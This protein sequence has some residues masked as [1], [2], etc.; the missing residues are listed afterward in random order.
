MRLSHLA[1]MATLVALLGAMFVA[2]PSAGA[3]TADPPMCGTSK[4]L[5]LGNDANNDD[6]YEDAEDTAPQTCTVSKTSNAITAATN[7]RVTV[8]AGSGAVATFGAVDTSTTNTGEVTFTA[9][10]AGQ[11]TYRVSIVA[12][13]ALSEP[14][15]HKLTVVAFSEQQESTSSS[16]PNFKISFVDDA[17]D[18]VSPGSSVDV[19]VASSGGAML[20]Q[21]TVAGGLSFYE[22]TTVRTY[23]ADGD[24]PDDDLDVTVAATRTVVG[25]SLL[26]SNFKVEVATSDVD[27]VPGATVLGAPK[28][29]WLTNDADTNSEAF[30]GGDVTTNKRLELAVPVGTA[31]GEYVVTAIGS[32]TRDGTPHTLVKTATLTV[33]DTAEV[34]TVSFGLS[35]PRRHELF[36]YVPGQPRV[37]LNPNSVDNVG[38]PPNG[39]GKDG[40]EDDT[41]TREPSSISVGS[42]NTTELSLSILNRAGKPSEANAI[43]SIVIST[44]GGSL[45]AKL[46]QRY[47]CD[48]V[49][50]TRACE[51]DISNYATAGE[52]LPSKIRVMLH[53][54]EAPGT[55]DVS[56]V[57]V[58]GGQVFTPD[59]VT[60]TFYGPVGALTLSEPSGTVLAYHT[61]SDDRDM[62]KFTVDATDA[63]G[64]AVR[65]P[66]VG[67][68]ITDP[69]GITVSPSKYMVHRS[70]ALNH[71]LQLDNDTAKASAWKTGDYEIAVSHGA[72]S[73]KATFTVVSAADAIELTLSDD[74]PSEV[75][76]EVLVTA[77]ITDENGNP[78]AD[79]TVVTI[80][81]PDLQGDFDSVVVADATSDATKGG[82][83]EVALV[84]V[85]PG[86]AVVRATVA[87]DETPVRKSAVLTSTAGA[88]EPVVE[89][90]PEPEVASVDCLSNLSGFSTW[91][92]GVDADVS[93]I[94]TMV[95]ERG[96]T[97]IHLW[98][99]TN[100]VRYSVVGGS[101]VPGSSDF[102][103][104]K[105]DI[106]YISQ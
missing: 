1:A 11:V 41:S 27:D 44:T 36:S 64:N 98:N 43:T 70:G 95:S 47:S 61:A 101:E 73:Q 39:T 15:L 24:D 3:Q 55:A 92:C 89:P 2:L 40:Y 72:L 90:E 69:D 79:G 88:P 83:A 9:A 78:V 74:M 86:R 50:V 20:S 32:Y 87:D 52:P 91:T 103:V 68:K 13:G 35:S 10:A 16:S 96:V 77:M 51:I 62:I 5:M 37:R 48:S 104:T 84:V 66:N 31:P 26:V 75:G 63:N 71:T 19:G 22:R 12:D 60:V 45:E 58:A 53:A 6:D 54:A 4:T 25:S 105:T 8:T 100:W 102:M 65:T 57:V 18:I 67:V 46:G 82:E 59:P 81:T 93:E 28:T 56:A 94:F 99:G 80:R 23:A 38:G 7:V 14:T 97:A 49:T 85:G 42:T 34:E 106:L 33:G 30:V 29:H 21:V 76:G 17:D